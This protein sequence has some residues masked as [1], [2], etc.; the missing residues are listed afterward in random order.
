MTRTLT[1][2]LT[3]TL[4]LSRRAYKKWLRVCV[5]AKPA[6]PTRTAME[7]LLSS[8]NANPSPSPCKNGYVHHL[9]LQ[10]PDLL[11][12]IVLLGLGMKVYVYVLV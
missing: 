3:V 9:S 4:V 7:L 12:L 2:T 1:L 10:L 8:P 6:I 5:C 11:N